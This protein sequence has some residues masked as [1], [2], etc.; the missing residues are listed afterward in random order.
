MSSGS[1]NTN[2]WLPLA[3]PKSLIGKQLYDYQL[4]ALS[5][6]RHVERTAAKGYVFRPQLGHVPKLTDMGME[7]LDLTDRLLSRGG[8]LADQ[9]GLGMLQLQDQESC[10]RAISSSSH[11]QRYLL[12]LTCVVL[13]VGKTLTTISL[14]LAHP[15]P[16]HTIPAQCCLDD[17]CL[18]SLP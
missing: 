2:T 3:Q 6:M 5:W 7:A 11:Q 17:R 9:M 1:S 16:K 4:R 10:L 14:I 18:S 13:R 8:I 15:K 12:L